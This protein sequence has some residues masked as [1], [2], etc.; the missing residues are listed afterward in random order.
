MESILFGGI[1]IIIVLSVL[2]FYYSYPSAYK[3]LISTPEWFVALIYSLICTY[4]AAAS[5]DFLD[6]G[7]SIIQMFIT[8]LVMILLITQIK[9]HTAT[10]IKLLSTFIFVGL[11]FI[12]SAIVPFFWPVHL[13]ILSLYLFVVF[14][15]WYLLSW[16]RSNGN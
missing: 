1:I 16:I 4:S 14:C 12:A 8:G 2:I 10:W 7:L 15:G 6:N 5:Y 9:E 13:M 11:V 3:I